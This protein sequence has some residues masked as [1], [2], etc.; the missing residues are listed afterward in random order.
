MKM[1]PMTIQTK[2]IMTAGFMIAIS[3][4][5]SNIFQ[6]NICN[7]V[8]AFSFHTKTSLPHN[9]KMIRQPKLKSKVVNL[10]VPLKMSERDLDMEADNET[11]KN[12][13]EDTKRQWELFTE[14]HINSQGKWQGTWTTY[15]Y[16]GDEIDSVL[17]SVVL[18][19]ETDGNDDAANDNEP[20]ESISHSHEIITDST[21]TDCDTCYDSTQARTIPVAK[22]MY[23][24]NKSNLA[25]RKIR[26][27]S[28]GM[29]VGPSLLRSGAMS[30]E[31]ILRHG[32][33]RLRVIFMHGP[34]WEKNVEPGSC[35]P[36]GLK[37]FRTTI[38]RESL[39]SE[40]RPFPG[41]TPETERQHPPKEGNPQFFR[42]V[43]PFQW[44]AQWKGSSWTYGEQ[45]GD[46]GWAIDEMEDQDAW[47][48]RPTG[49]TEN[50]WSL[51]LP[52][53]ILLQCPRMVYPD[54][55]GLCRLAWMPEGERG[56]DMLG[57]LLR[58][59]TGVT[60][61]QPI[62]VGDDA[63]NDEVVGFHPP[64]LVSLRC[65]TLRKTGE[66]EG[67]SLL[68]PNSNNRKLADDRDVLR[69]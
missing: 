64:S 61:L 49:D 30:T 65:D 38:S 29:S 19:R 44:H 23:D 58:L 26:L 37:L 40:D 54:E 25:Q 33:S 4:N 5:I 53:G 12:E 9:L 16:M 8:N 15:D 57:A 67:T 62:V 45:N 31:L 24:S 1:A 28:V 59:E 60:A 56:P 51:R 11:N 41:P 39:L 63:F 66:L 7:G 48:G 68:N 47:H 6:S 32:D 22:Y 21:T 42:P 35:P 10:N 20:F 13:V 34:A 52:G 18:K 69:P 14:N 3:V 36:M 17:A 27:A 46:K 55:V 2:R 43:P 50:V